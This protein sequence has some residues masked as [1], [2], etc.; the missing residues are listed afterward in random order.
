MS[1]IVKLEDI[2]KEAEYIINNNIE[3][4]SKLRKMLGQLIVDDVKKDIDNWDG[5]EIPIRSLISNK[6]TLYEFFE[7][8][9]NIFIPKQ[10][11]NYIYLYNNISEFRNTNQ[12]DNLEFSVSNPSIKILNIIDESNNIHKRELIDGKVTLETSN[13]CIHFGHYLNNFCYNKMSIKEIMN[14]LTQDIKKY[15]DERIKMLL[16]NTNLV[17]NLFHIKPIK[18]GMDGD[19][20]LMEINGYT[21]LYFKI[22]M[23]MLGFSVKLP[24]HH[25][26]CTRCPQF[27]LKS[28]STD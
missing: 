6:C 26:D 11:D 14:A 28:C 12:G 15:I 21:K 9:I 25:I 5:I 10:L 19:G 18:I 13:L 17:L 22:G 27:D 8:L 7:D 20:I 1:E 23:G 2:V 16:E 3:D 4:E 24:C